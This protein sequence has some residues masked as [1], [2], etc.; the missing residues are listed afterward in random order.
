LTDLAGLFVDAEDFLGAVLETAAQ[1]IWVVDPGR[2]DPVRQSGRDRPERREGV[3]LGGH[4]GA[5]TSYVVQEA[6]GL[7]A[8]PGE[9][10]FVGK[11]R[12]GRA[13]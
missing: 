4:R 7:V 6:G 1:P 8:G 2:P 5:S 10:G 13:P 3:A 11:Q 9:D 12:Y